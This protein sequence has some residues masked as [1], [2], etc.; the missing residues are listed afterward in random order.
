MFKFACMQ[1]RHYDVQDVAASCKIRAMPTFQIY[2][3]GEKV[4][5]IVGANPQQLE[6]LAAQYNAT[7]SSFV[8]QGRK[9]GGAPITFSAVRLDPAV[10]NVFEEE[11][12]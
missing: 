3:Q 11:C 1:V 8:G 12:F 10:Q 4:E 5:E 7:S 2:K 9:L 6:A